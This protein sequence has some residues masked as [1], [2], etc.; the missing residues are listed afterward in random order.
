MP[1]RRAL[2]IGTG[3]AALATTYRLLRSDW[4]VTLAD[5]QNPR[6]ADEFPFPLTG[7]GFEAAERF[8]LLPALS[9]RRQPPCALVRVDATGLPLAVRPRPGRRSP[10]LRPQDV[11]EVL[12]EALGPL[13]TRSAPISLTP[14][15][16]GVTAEFANHDEDWFDLVVG[17][18]GPDS[19]VRQALF[20]PAPA[21][22]GWSTLSDRIAMRPTCAV[23]MDLETRSVRLHPL[24]DGNAAVSFRWPAGIAW[25]D[26]FTDLGWLVPELLSLVDGSHRVRTPQEPPSRWTHRRVVLIGSAAWGTDATA[27]LSLGAAELLGD[28]LDIFPDED[29]SLRWWDQTL[30][31]C[32][33]RATKRLVAV[34]RS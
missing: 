10:V 13:P 33:R 14:D 24:H 1:T 11:I 31:P 23:A 12:H 19:Q 6:P 27:A 22:V 16:W 32:A 26:A 15:S 9:E 30:R 7:I 4:E 18:D 2:V 3:V 29:T 20:G 21:P 34:H 17:A 8:G 5:E 28:A 25:P